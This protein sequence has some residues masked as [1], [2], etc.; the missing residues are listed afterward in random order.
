MSNP[1]SP[2]LF[3][4]GSSR[5]V[6]FIE[7]GLKENQFSIFIRKISREFPDDILN[8]FIYNKTKEERLW[9]V[10]LNLFFWRK[11]CIVIFYIITGIS[12]VSIMGL[13]LMM[14]FGMSFSIIQNQ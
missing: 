14:T 3:K 12:M 11:C 7:D 1:T 2:Y 10:W 9:I 6:K 4:D 5:D 8:D 13:M